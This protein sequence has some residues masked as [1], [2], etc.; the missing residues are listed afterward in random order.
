M[1]RGNYAICMSD[2]LGKN[3]DTRIQLCAA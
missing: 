1:L 2:S 3:T